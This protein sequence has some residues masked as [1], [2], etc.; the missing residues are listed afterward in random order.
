TVAAGSITF[1]KRK[2]MAAQ[3]AGRKKFPQNAHRVLLTRDRQGMVIF[4]PPGEKK[5]PTRS[6]EYDERTYQY[7]GKIGIP[8]LQ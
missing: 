7:L 4:V 3:K 6:P 1:S 5:D 8:V 2:D